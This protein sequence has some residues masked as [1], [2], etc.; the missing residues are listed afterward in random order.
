MKYFGTVDSFDE[1]KGL[2]FIKPETTGAKIG[3][4]RDSIAWD[5]KA[6]PVIGKRLSYE[7]SDTKGDNSA[8][9]LQHA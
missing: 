9:N 7:I 2:G 5:D 3:F 1:S 6:P 4:E 8:I